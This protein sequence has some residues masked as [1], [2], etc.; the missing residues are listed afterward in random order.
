M[1]HIN[2]MISLFVIA[3]G[4]PAAIRLAGIILYMFGINAGGTPILV[5][6]IVIMSGI[7]IRY[8]KIFRNRFE[9]EQQ[10]QQQQQQGPQQG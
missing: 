3:C 7:S 2:S 8:S 4:A 6:M 10:Q 9:Q 5:A 1:S